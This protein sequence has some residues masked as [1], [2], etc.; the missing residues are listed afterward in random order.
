MSPAHKPAL[1]LLSSSQTKPAEQTEQE[2]IASIR[3]GDERAFAAM[4]EMYAPVLLAFAE[5]YVE[6]ADDA[7]DVVEEVFVRLWE[8][9]ANWTVHT[10]IKTYLMG[11]VHNRALKT[12]RSEKV[13]ERWRLNPHSSEVS[14]PSVLMPAADDNVEAVEL[15]DILRKLIG[16]LPEPRRTAITLRWIDG[17]SYAEIAE[18]LQITVIAVKKQLN[19][20]LKEMKAKAPEYLR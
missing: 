18:L 10:T 3:L 16:T 4:F 12:R 5:R 20:A 17:L 9:R 7:E 15:G 14:A 6:S 19:R 11:A 1:R 8:T 13:R 2:W